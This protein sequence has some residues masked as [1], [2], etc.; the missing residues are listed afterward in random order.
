MNDRRIAWLLPTMGRGG[1]SWQHLLCEFTRSF[2]KT[3]TFTGE[4]AGYVPGYENTF[5]V[6]EV[7][8]TRFVETKQ[9]ASG[10]G[11]G[12]SYASP[13]IVR[14]LLHFKPQVVFANAF[15]IWT[16]LALLLK[17][18]GGWRLIIT[19]EG[20]SPNVDYQDSPLRLWSRK[21][22]AQGADALV[23]NSQSG[24]HYIINYLGADPR[25]VFARPFLVPS[26]K[27]LMQQPDHA[28]THLDPNLPRPIFLY[29]GQMIARKGTK[30]LLEA[31]TWLQ[32]QGYQ[33]YTLLMVGDG[34]QRSELETYTRT[35]GLTEQ[36]RW[37]G[38]IEYGALGSYFQQA[39]VF[40][41]PTYEDI[42]GMVLP[43]AMALGKP[44]LCS[45]EAGAVELMAHGKNG[46]I[47]QPDQPKEL[48]GYMQQ[49]L[50]QPNHIQD[51]GAASVQMMATHTPEQ[52]TQCFVDA[53]EFV[54]GGKSPCA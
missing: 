30:T 27:A 15:S 44:V 14:E 22:M 7:G 39:D 6:Q 35:A 31:C 19:Y 52:A 29:V 4:W 12:F 8:E 42:W 48:A 43:E 40:V 9:G 28:Q 24:K 34:E 5:Q 53:V 36:V 50:D 54:A 17:P 45:K 23:A 25:K 18:I 13:G 3:V 16:L 41:F 1:I 26:L 11:F 2:P 10:Y 47:F 20:S 37:L 51:M 38:K 32:A 21:I 49:F 33:N 46:Y